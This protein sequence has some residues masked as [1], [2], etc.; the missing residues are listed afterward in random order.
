MKQHTTA[1]GYVMLSFVSLIMLILSLPF[2]EVSV[3]L[4]NIFQMYSGPS[5]RLHAV[6]LSLMTLNNGLYWTRFGVHRPL[7]CKAGQSNEQCSIA[8]SRT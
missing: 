5:T 2:I 6:S 4:S 3:A 8:H 1:S 7:I